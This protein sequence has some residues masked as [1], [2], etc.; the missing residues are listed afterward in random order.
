MIKKGEKKGL[1]MAVSL[2]VVIALAILILILVAVFL[3]RSSG[4]FKDKVDSYLGSSNIDSLVS[5]CNNLATQESSYEYC[6]TNRTAKFSSTNS[7]QI[8][9]AKASEQTWGKNIQ[10]L[11]CDGLC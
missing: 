6:C 7:S 5:N 2:I 1:E 3:T 11:N 10:K 9:C 4:T 8:S